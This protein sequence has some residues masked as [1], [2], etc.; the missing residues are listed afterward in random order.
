LVEGNQ[1]VF[2]SLSERLIGSIDCSKLRRIYWK[3]QVD[4][5]SIRVK[6]LNLYKK[7]REEASRRKIVCLIAIGNFSLQ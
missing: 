6:D 2:G 5:N 3:H 1:V 7:R 4:G